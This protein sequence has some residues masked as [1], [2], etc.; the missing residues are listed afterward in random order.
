MLLVHA[1]LLTPPSI[2]YRKGSLTPELADWN[3]I[4]QNFFESEPITR[5]S[6]L[7]LSNEQ[8]SND[9]AN[10]LQNALAKC[11]MKRKNPDPARGFQVQLGPNGDDDQNDKLIRDVMEEMSKTEV[12]IVLVILPFK[13][14]PLY[15]RVKYWADVKFGMIRG[16]GGRL[17]K[18]LTSNNRHSHRMLC[19]T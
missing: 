6:Y 7:N 10:K 4:G 17:N 19:S 1:R 12:R 14:A 15:A 5:W 13:S 16:N 9:F 8:L 11:G 18:D 2:N 3:M